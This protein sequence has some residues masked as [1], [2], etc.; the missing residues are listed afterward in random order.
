[1]PAT[2]AA[3]AAALLALAV[4]AARGWLDRPQPV[5]V[6]ALPLDSSIKVAVRGAVAAPGVYTLRPGDRV[7]D[8]LRAAGGLLPE[9]DERALN[10]AARLVDEQEIWVPRLGEGASR[11][12]PTRSPASGRVNLNTATLAQLIE[13]PGIAELTAQ[14]IIE[15]RQRVGPFQRVEELRERGI[16][17]AQNFELVKDRVTAP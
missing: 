8:A 5:Q 4:L 2:L 16:M 12:L 15:S 10:P 9:A 1:M 11:P 17:N 7:E 3:T 6:V 13:L 14:R